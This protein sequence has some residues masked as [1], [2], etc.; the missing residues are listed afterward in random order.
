[1]PIYGVENGI[2]N[3]PLLVF[4][5]PSYLCSLA[6]SISCSL[7][8]IFT[9]TST[10]YVKWHK[11]SCL[12]SISIS[13]MSQGQFKKTMVSWNWQSEVHVHKIYLPDIIGLWKVKYNWGLRSGKIP[14]IQ[15]L[16]ELFSRWLRDFT[17]RKFKNVQ[18]F[19]IHKNMDSL[20]LL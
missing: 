19:P 17:I 5:S 12:W 7:P 6:N 3:I 10:R 9:F 1:M 4:L 11:V 2:F 15:V 18:N 16:L 13:S 14:F 20:N 8:Y